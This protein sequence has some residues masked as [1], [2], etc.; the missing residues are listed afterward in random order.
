MR[1]FLV[2]GIIGF[3]FVSELFAQIHPDSID[4]IFPIE[5]SYDPTSNTPQSF[6]LGDPSNVEKTIVYDPKTGKY[7]F[8][9]KM[10]SDL[11]YRNPSMMTLEEYI[12]YERQREMSEYW[13]EKIDDQTEE[14]QPLIPPIKI[15]SK[16]F[17]NIFGSD[18]INIRP[19]GAVEL[20]FGVNSSRYDNPI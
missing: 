1:L 20:S 14:G 3:G 16:A 4:L 9:E 18:E 13:R 5:N 11:N 2:I 15:E 10:G 17:A 12:E 7:V 19:T 8:R 6:D